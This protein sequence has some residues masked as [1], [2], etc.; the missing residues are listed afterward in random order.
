MDDNYYSPREKALLTKQENK[1]I[2]LEELQ[3]LRDLLRKKFDE[4]FKIVTMKGN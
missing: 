1:D 2:T 4:N 3:E